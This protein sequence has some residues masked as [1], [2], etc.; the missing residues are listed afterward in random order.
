MLNYPGVIPGEWFAQ[1]TITP[2][3]INSIRNNDPLFIYKVT[4]DLDILYYHQAMKAIDKKQ[5]LDAMDKEINDQMN[6]NNFNIIY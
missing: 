6:N 1:E 5:L 2:K 3:G 4:L